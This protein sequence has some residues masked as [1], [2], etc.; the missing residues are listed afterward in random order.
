MV[1]AKAVPAYWAAGWRGIIHVPPTDK[2]PPPVTDLGNGLK[3]S[4]TGAEGIDTDA[5]TLAGWAAK[6]PHHSA[7]LRMPHG[8]IA[9][10]VDHYDKTSILPDGTTKTVEKR[11]N[12]TLAQF[13]A[14]WG[15][16]P[17][18]WCS[19][20]RGTESAAGPSRTLFYRVPVGRYASVLG[21]AVEILQRHHRYCVVAPSI[22][23]HA[24]HTP[25]RWYQPDG[26]LA[27]RYPAPA[28]LAELPG[29]W[30]AGLAEGA[31]AVSPAA[32]PV[33]LGQSLL[34]ALAG[35]ADTACADMT[36]ALDTA[37]AEFAAAET[38]G[39]H[40]VATAR[41]YQIIQLGAVGHPGVGYAMASLR[42]H[43]EALTAGEDREG[44]WDRI[45]LTA[46]RKA[47]SVVGS[48]PV[49]VDPCLMFS[50]GGTYQPPAAGVASTGTPLPPVGSAENPAAGVP[51]YWSLREIIGTGLFDPVGML[52]QHMAAAVLERM[53]PGL[54]YAT[55]ASTWLLRGQSAWQTGGSARWAV[56]Y[57]LDRMP[58]GNLDAEVGT[59]ERYRAERR[60]RFGS[61]QGAS[62]IGAKMDALVTHDHPCGVRLSDLDTDPHVFWSAGMPW[63]LANCADGV[64]RPAPIDPATPHLHSGAIAPALDARAA[65]TPYWDAFLAEVWP[66][67]AVRAWA[68]SV[69]AVGFTGHADAVLPI[70]LGPTGRGKTALVILLMSL[71]GDYAHVADPRLLTSADNSHASIVYALKGRRWSFIDEG[72][73]EGKLATER[74]KQ[75]TGGAALTGNS[76]RQDPVTFHPTHTLVLTA[77]PPGPS[78]QDEAVRRRVRLLPCDGDP[79]SIAGARAA[80]TPAVWAQEAPGVLAGMLAR[81][82]Q[83]IA[84]RSVAGRAA[85]PEDIRLRPEEIAAEQDL[86]ATWIDAEMEPS[87]DGVGTRVS[88]LYKLH[89][90]WRRGLGPPLTTTAF[91]I[92]LT[93][94]GYPAAKAAGV[95]HRG[96]CVRPP[97][98]GF[99]PFVPPPAQ[100]TNGVHL[101]ENKPRS[102]KNTADAQDLQTGG[103]QDQTRAWMAVWLAAYTSPDVAGTRVSVLHEGCNNWLISQGQSPVDVAE[104]GATLEY[105]GFSMIK[106][107][108]NNEGHIVQIGQTGAGGQK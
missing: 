105:L 90:D 19:T 33:E 63:D 93:K 84:D 17:P 54:R 53:W 20:A 60:K 73:R 72:P 41:M 75:L 99:V 91:G 103:K 104:F 50:F 70:L 2:Y 23:P 31:A 44:E 101:P 65:P 42:G 89:S 14:S 69:L 15:A 88:V 46:A 57:L 25:Y 97:Q 30:V 13:E 80:I 12:D 55:D 77:N 87:G 79:V 3:I 96:L 26:R 86:V 59:L 47:V 98:S 6:Y 68:L 64:M 35:E 29:E 102:P 66:D 11:G 85:A 76:M 62:S 81:A 37:H 82:S 7:A 4:Y 21:P 32:A 1:F 24:G 43:W 48:T 10:D 34:A 22:N 106:T 56:A 61:A 78:F 8:V 28:E 74:L 107:E 92:E 45:C 58:P 108:I 83:W 95:W 39:R 38:G 9:I 40:D 16:L 18:S 5:V 100:G 49:A 71:L 94:L 27:D 51:V 67:P 36:R 52:D